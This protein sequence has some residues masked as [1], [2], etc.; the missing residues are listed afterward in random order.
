MK[1]TPCKDSATYLQVVPV[2]KSPFTGSI[3]THLWFVFFTALYRE[4][5]KSITADEKVRRKKELEKE[6]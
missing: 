3:H 6:Q 2:D 4:V 1:A 5:F